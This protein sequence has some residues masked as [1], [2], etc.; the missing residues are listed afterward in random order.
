MPVLHARYL[1]RALTARRDPPRLSRLFSELRHHTRTLNLPRQPILAARAL[2]HVSPRRPPRPNLLLLPGHRRPPLPSAQN[3]HQRPPLQ[4]RHHIPHPRHRG[5]R[6]R[7][8]LRPAPPAAALH[9]PPQRCRVG[10]CPGPE[11]PPD[12]L[13]RRL[14]R[15]DDRPAHARRLLAA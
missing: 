2:H 6:A 13:Q 4:P 15:G 3:L 11:P 9:L 8:L 10:G 5:P 7:P 1:T 12:R 14:G